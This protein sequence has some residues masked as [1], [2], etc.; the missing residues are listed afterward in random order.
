MRR[1]YF[2]ILLIFQLLLH[3]EEK[4]ICDGLTYEHLTTDEPQSI[5]ILRIDP[6]LLEISAAR[7][8]DDGIGRETVSSL[9]SRHGAIA[10]I[11]GGFFQIGGTLDGLPQGILKIKSNWYGLPSKPRGAIGW[12]K[13][14]DLLIDRLLATCLIKTATRNFLSMV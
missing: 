12:N 10:A 14:G 7:A 1:I 13:K 3:S 2:F 8:L 4:L 9:S 6:T 11:N 5:H